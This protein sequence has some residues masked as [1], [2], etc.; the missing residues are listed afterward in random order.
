M[1]VCVATFV[2]EVPT[3]TMIMGSVWRNGS[4]LAHRKQTQLKCIYVYCIYGTL[5]TVHEFPYVTQFHT[6]ELN[7]SIKLL[8]MVNYF[9]DRSTNDERCGSTLTNI[10]LARSPPLI[11][12]I[13]PWLTDDCFDFRSLACSPLFCNTLQLNCNRSQIE[14]SW[15]VWS[16]LQ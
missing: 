1:C 16:L 12:D 9:E 6:K 15:R 2:L 5:W 7:M 14:W 10:S 4:S 11:I 13:S 3:P 8:W